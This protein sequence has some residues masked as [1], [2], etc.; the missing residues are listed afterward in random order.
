ML[1]RGLVLGGSAQY[2][3]W[4][5]SQYFL[6]R[7][8]FAVA[9]E[10]DRRIDLLLAAEE[11]NEEEKLPPEAHLRR[12]MA[13]FYI[14][15][16]DGAEADFTAVLA[17]QPKETRAK[18]G[19]LFISVMRNDWKTAVGHLNT[20]AKAG[21]LKKGDRVVAEGSFSDPKKFR[22]VVDGLVGHAQYTISDGDAHLAAAWAL[23]VTGQDKMARSYARLARRWKPSNAAL[24]VIEKNLG[25]GKKTEA[26]KKA[27]QAPE[28]REAPIPA[29]AGKDEPLG[30]R[31][32]QAPAAG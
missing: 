4:Y 12:G 11:L 17:A 6:H 22:A 26:R 32:A 3:R 20:L 27:E 2:R 5:V 23:A 28:T 31:V 16:Y 8:P 21:E 14:A 10:E 18:F 15:D 1:R 25:I 30:R 19:H 29:P 13:R 9:E 7:Y 24:P